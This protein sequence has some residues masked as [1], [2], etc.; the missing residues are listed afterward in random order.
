MTT[1]H[2]DCDADLHLKLAGVLDFIAI[3]RG[4]IELRGLYYCTFCV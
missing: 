3:V 2:G 4:V 1:V